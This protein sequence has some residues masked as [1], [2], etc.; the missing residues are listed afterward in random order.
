MH[1]IEPTNWPHLTRPPLCTPYLWG[2]LKALSFGE[3]CHVVRRHIA[4]DEARFG[5]DHMPVEQSVLLAL[6][7]DGR[8][9]ATLLRAIERDFDLEEARLSGP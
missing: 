9:N 5:G 4:L 6:S 8:I 7:S 2:G 3:A 1:Q